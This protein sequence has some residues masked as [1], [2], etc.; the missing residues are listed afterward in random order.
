M[1][2]VSGLKNRLCSKYYGSIFNCAQRAI[3]YDKIFNRLDNN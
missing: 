3:A 1:Q 2:L